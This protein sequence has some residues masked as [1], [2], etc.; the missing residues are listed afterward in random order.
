MGH[1]PRGRAH[2]YAQ[3]DNLYV[4]ASGYFPLPWW[5]GFAVLVGWAALALGLASVRLRRADA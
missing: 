4:V 3:V 1:D 2:E 5:G